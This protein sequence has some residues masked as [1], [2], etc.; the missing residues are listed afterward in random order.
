V[1]KIGTSKAGGTISQQAAVHIRSLP[2]KPIKK[3]KT[4]R[5]RTKEEEEEEEEEE[6]KKKKSERVEAK[7][8]QLYSLLVG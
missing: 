7:F 1:A 2:R 5:K 8:D 6:E 4:R 3:K